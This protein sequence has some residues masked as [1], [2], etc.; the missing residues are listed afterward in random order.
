MNFWGGKK[1]CGAQV[2]SRV[3]V[4]YGENRIHQPESFSISVAAIINRNTRAW[5]EVRIRLTEYA[6]ERGEY[7]R[8]ETKMI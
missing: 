6:D 1:A 3:T 8:E 4:V 2:W 5:L 7:G